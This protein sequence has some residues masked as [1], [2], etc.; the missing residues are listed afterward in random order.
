MMADRIAITS[1]P[2][3]AHQNPSTTRPKPKIVVDSQLTSM[4]SSP[5]TMSARRPSV[6]MYSGKATTR[7]IEP[8]MPLTTPKIKATSRRVRIDGRTPES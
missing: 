5:F 3:T 6:R 1:A 7:M 4:S 2:R 8:R